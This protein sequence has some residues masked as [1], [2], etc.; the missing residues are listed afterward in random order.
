MIVDG[1]F[2]FRPELVDCWDFTVWIDVSFDEMINRAVA[3]DVAWVGSPEKV[4]RRYV[5]RYVPLHLLYEA[6]TGARDRAEVLIDNSDLAHPKML[7]MPRAP[8]L[9]K[10]AASSD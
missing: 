6:R 7:R 2:L 1:A 5:E 9:L 4:R 10:R 8:E 3:R